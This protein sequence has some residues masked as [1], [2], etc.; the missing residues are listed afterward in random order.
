MKFEIKSKDACGRI[1]KLNT[2]HGTITTPTLLPV[3]NPSKLVIPPN[4]MKK[5]GVEMVITNSYI[6]RKNE[7]LREK[8]LEEGVH[9]LI[10]FHGPIMTDSGTFQSYVYGDRNIDPLDIVLFQR[11][12]DVDIGT[13]L[14]VFTTPEQSKEEVKKSIEE[15]IRRAKSSIE[16]KNEMSL[17][18]TVQGSI[19]PDLRKKCAEELSKL[20]ADLFPIGGVV[21]LME[22]QRYLDLCKVILSSKKALPAGKPVHLFGAGHP[23]I[24]SLAVALGCDIFDSSAYVKY[25][26]EDRLIFSWGTAH[27][28][29]LEEIACCCPI[30]SKISA[31]ELKKLDKNQRV[32][33]IAR[34]NL[35]VSMIEIKKIRNAIH[36]GTL[37]TLVEQKASV[38]PLIHDAL[39]ELEKKNNQQWFERFETTSKNRALFYTGHH[40]IFQPILYR[41]FDR[42][43][44]R[45]KFISDQLIFLPEVSKPYSSTYSTLI[46]DIFN[47]NP[48]VDIIIDSSIGPIPILLDEMYPFAQSV[49]PNNLDDNSKKIKKKVLKDFIKG[50]KIIKWNGKETLKQISLKDEQNKSVDIDIRR[51]SAVANMQFGMNADKALFD[52]DIK[53]IKSKKTGKIRNVFCDDEHVVSMRASDGMFTLKINGAK[54]LHRFFK[55]PFLRIIVDE[56]SV[57]FIL[58]GKSVFTKF[59]LSCDSNLR[60]LDEC[61]IVDKND[62][63]L[64]NGR[65]MLNPEEMHSFSYGMAV[66]V[67]EH[68]LKDNINF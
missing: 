20:D 45:Y 28:K 18:C 62:T 25:A 12:I 36:N 19:Y 14:D 44:T 39:K 34:H 41:V 15:T 54:K 42:L 2:K 17:A 6:I 37:W 56:D 9:D 24:F 67:R 35:Y 29:D 51:I 52:G 59:V 57:P 58:D 22:S 50:K 30:C 33:Q 23:I 68:E 43:L 40:T 8:A 47:V 60:A 21:P 27:L 63:F 7:D 10:N 64:A 65:C 3:I 61:I 49:F 26:L 16:I 53:I 32:E 66:K 5:F 46:E 1:A 13:I 38:N 11:N 55:N 31:N 48:N 4:E